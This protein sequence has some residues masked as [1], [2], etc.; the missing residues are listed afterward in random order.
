MPKMAFGKKVSVP[1]CDDAPVVSIELSSNAKPVTLIYPYYENPQTLRRHI[2]H[3]SLLP[4]YLQP[5]LRAII[6]D[7]GSPDHP[8]VE[9]MAE[10]VTSFPISL[11]R[12]EVDV[13]WNWLAARNI[14]WHH[15]QDGWCVVTDADH[16]IPQNTLVGLIY[17]E[18]DE[19]TIYRF[20]R[21]EHTG[22][23]IHPH[24]NSWFMTREMYWRVGGYDEALSGHYGTDGEYRRRCVKTAPVHIMADRLV[25][26]E[27]VGDASTVR[28]LRKQPEDAAVSR[29]VAARGKDW[30]PKTLSFP[31]HQVAL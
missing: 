9:V 25:R 26:H 13:R 14:G 20:M 19:G 16:L 7:D 29:M 31:Y 28:Y 21:E 22:Q 6:V 11:Y 15:A 1:G 3:W 23:V 12:I 2:E 24:P 4:D 8:A 10:I 18:H 30:A 5:H 27:H 17:G